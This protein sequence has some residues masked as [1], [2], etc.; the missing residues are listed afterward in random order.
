MSD[1]AWYI[2]PHLIID[3]EKYRGK[4][5]PRKSDYRMYPGPND[6]YYHAPASVDPSGWVMSIGE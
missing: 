4:G 6:L 1:T 3:R 2:V 5:R